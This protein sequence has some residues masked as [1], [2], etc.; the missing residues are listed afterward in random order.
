V[1]Q[2]SFNDLLINNAVIQ[3][4]SLLE[5]GGD[6]HDVGLSVRQKVDENDVRNG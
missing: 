5:V 4:Q 1:K 2:Q 6:H 3:D